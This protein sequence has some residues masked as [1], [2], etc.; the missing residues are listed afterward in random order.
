M[1]ERDRAHKCGELRLGADDELERHVH[2]EI[3]LTQVGE[4]GS[5]EARACI[6]RTDQRTA[7]ANRPEIVHCSVE[8]LLVRLRR[9]DDEC[10]A[11][12]KHGVDPLDRAI[13]D[14]LRTSAAPSPRRRP[15]T[16]VR[17]A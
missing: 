7:G 16:T 11:G 6:R 1:P 5:F 17:A 9:T 3:G 8:R 10:S 15:G 2:P 4:L 12:P 14:A 13:E